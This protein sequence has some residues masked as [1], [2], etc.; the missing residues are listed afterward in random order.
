MN[1]PERLLESAGTLA[2]RLLE[3]GTAERPPLHSLARTMATL[4]ERDRP[5]PWT[6]RSMH[7]SIQRKRPRRLW[8]LLALL[9]STAFLMG[10]VVSYH[11]RAQGEPSQAS[12]GQSASV[13]RLSRAR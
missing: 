10:A 12:S 9:A 11:W 5:R 2:R 13:G 1:E 3:S 8:P 6:Q 4:A 7:S